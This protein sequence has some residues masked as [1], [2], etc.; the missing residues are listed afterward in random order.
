MLSDS[1]HVPDF[2]PKT[3]AGT[4]S[5]SNL[6]KAGL[7]LYPED[8]KENTLTKISSQEK[9]GYL[10]STYGMFSHFENNGKAITNTSNNPNES[11]LGKIIQ[12]KSD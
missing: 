5:S 9:Y 10:D 8:L 7:N 4:E 2:Y 3:T 12:E 1:V 6:T 11:N